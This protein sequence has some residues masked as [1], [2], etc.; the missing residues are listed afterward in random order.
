M[1]LITITS[2]DLIN[3]NAKT[4]TEKKVSEIANILKTRKGEIPF[5]RGVGISDEFIDNPITTIKPA[6]INDITAVIRET[7]D[8]VSLQSVEIIANESVGDYTIKVVCEI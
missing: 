5:M 2:D 1:A 7:V 4:K 3:W 6:L 8:N